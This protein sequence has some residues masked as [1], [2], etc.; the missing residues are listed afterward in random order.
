MVIAVGIRVKKGDTRLA[1][2]SPPIGFKHLWSITYTRTNKGPG[3][4]FELEYR[5]SDKTYVPVQCLKNIWAVKQRFR[6]KIWKYNIHITQMSEMIFSIST[7]GTGRVPRAEYHGATL[8]R[9]GPRSME[10]SCTLFRSDQQKVRSPSRR[11]LGLFCW[12]FLPLSLPASFV[13]SPPPPPPDLP[14]RRD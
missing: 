1:F 2:C 6:W 3:V 12:I 5:R 11:P 10:S 14:S 8:P 4:R 9:T 7:T 13:S